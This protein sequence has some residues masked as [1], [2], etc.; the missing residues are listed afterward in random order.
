MIVSL[1]LVNVSTVPVLS[2]V[3]KN[4]LYS[5]VFAMIGGLLLVPLVSALTQKTLPENVDDMFKCY[6]VTRTV[7]VTD[8]L[9]DEE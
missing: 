2:L 6:T 4:S 5:G 7:E 3:F 8:N 1:G 9:G